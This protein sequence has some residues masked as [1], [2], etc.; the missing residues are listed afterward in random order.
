MEMG[1]PAPPS[2][3]KYLIIRFHKLYII[4]IYIIHKLRFHLRSV[5]NKHG[6]QKMKQ[7]VNEPCRKI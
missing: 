6:M 1:T 7:N 5:C 3:Q 2:Y 4:I